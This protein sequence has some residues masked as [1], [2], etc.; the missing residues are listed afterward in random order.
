V[1]GVKCCIWHAVCDVLTWHDMFASRG[2]WTTWRQRAIEGIMTSAHEHG[3]GVISGICG[4]Q[5]MAEHW[6]SSRGLRGSSWSSMYEHSSQQSRSYVSVDSG[7]G[8]F[9]RVTS[10]RFPSVLWWSWR[11][12]N[13]NE[14]LSSMYEV[15]VGLPGVL[16][17][18]RCFC[19][20][21]LGGS[22]GRSYI[23]VA[24]IRF[25]AEQI[26]FKQKTA[27]MGCSVIL[28]WFTFNWWR[29]ERDFALGKCWFQKCVPRGGYRAHI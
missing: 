6:G 12:L 2:V 7:L 25:G 4:K 26:I 15:L 9:Q 1:S 17:V 22:K 3:L 28:N 19:L 16:G 24:N 18:N 5:N 23:M 11:F 27:I 13:V 10:G 14:V 8:W 20:R 21:H 29:L